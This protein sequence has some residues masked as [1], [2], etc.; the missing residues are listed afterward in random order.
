[1]DGNQC[2]AIKEV[3]HTCVKPCDLPCSGIAL[4][5]GY[6]FWLPEPDANKSYKS[7]KLEKLVF[8]FDFPQGGS[9]DLSADVQS[10]I[11]VANLN[12]LNANFAVVVQKWLDQI[13][14]LIA[15]ITGKPDWLKLSYE[16]D[17]PGTLGIL[18]IEYFECLEFDIQIAS[19][20]RRS[21]VNE[22]LSVA[23][24]PKGTTLTLQSLG[25]ANGEIVNIPAFDGTK[26][27]KCNPGTPVETLCAKAPALALKI[28]KQL[29]GLTLSVNVTPSRSDIPVVAYL[30][31]VQDANPAMANT[32]K[33]KFT[34]TSTDPKP[35]RIRVTAFTVEGCRVIQD[36]TIILG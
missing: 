32:Q 6:R 35:K 5:R 30:W 25:Q 13:N 7:F 28:G 2:S 11:Q 3:T 18:W 15:K 1:M 8:L 31:E 14:Q 20:F 9:V 34:F 21:D 22:G 26:I 24:S 23:Y 19:S 4:R 17:K 36:D 27:D 12:D 16:S 10:I 29:D 33:A